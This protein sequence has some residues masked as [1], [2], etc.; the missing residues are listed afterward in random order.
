MFRQFDPT[1]QDSDRRSCCRW[2]HNRQSRRGPRS[3]PFLQDEIRRR[4]RR[5]RT[6]PMSMVPVSLR[7]R[8]PS[9]ANRLLLLSNVR[10][11]QDGRLVITV[12]RQSRGS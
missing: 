11:L 8:S 7:S 2:D 12:T 6:I 1:V 4:I 10:H 5:Y 9:L 3:S